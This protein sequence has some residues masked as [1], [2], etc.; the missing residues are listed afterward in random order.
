MLSEV[1]LSTY[2]SKKDFASKLPISINR[3]FPTKKKKKPTYLGTYEGPVEEYRLKG[4]ICIC[5]I[6]ISKNV[7]Y[8]NL[9]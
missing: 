3:L 7:S 1:Y 2:Y 5:I 4:Q 6:H 8:T 9:C